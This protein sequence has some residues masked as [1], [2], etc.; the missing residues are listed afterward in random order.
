[1]SAE[2]DP[3]PADDVAGRLDDERRMRE[4]LPAVRRLPRAERE[5]VA[6]CLWSG[7]SYP[8]A[9]AVLGAA[10]PQVAPESRSGLAVRAALTGRCRRRGPARRHRDWLPGPVQI[11]SLSSSEFSGGKVTALGRIS[12]R[13]HRLVLEHGNGRS[14]TTARLSRGAFGLV[15]RNDDVGSGATLVSY[16]SEDREIGRREL[17]RPFNESDRCYTDPAGTVVYGRQ[18]PDCVPADPW[19]R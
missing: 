5:A 10:V 19:E 13:V 4:I 2:H 14:T 12:P 9:A 8:E 17:F 15:T 18:G 6:L 7:V 16:D 11:L 3:D 1:V